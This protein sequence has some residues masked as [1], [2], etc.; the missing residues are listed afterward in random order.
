MF[1][2]EDWTEKRNRRTSKTNPERLRDLWP[3]EHEAGRRGDAFWGLF[4]SSVES[5][6]LSLLQRRKEGCVPPFESET[7]AVRRKGFF[8]FFR[9]CGVIFFRAID[10]PVLVMC[11]CRR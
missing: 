7:A 9:L 1:R 8:S 5:V 4:K 11:P 6:R 10:V 3:E 2:E